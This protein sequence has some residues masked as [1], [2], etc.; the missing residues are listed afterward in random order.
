[1]DSYQRAHNPYVTVKAK[2]KLEETFKKN[3]TLFVRSKSN[4]SVAQ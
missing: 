3:K 2:R 1:M 4:L